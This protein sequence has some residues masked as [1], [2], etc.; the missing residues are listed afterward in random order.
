[1]RDMPK[2]AGRGLAIGVVP[3]AGL[4]CLAWLGS[5]AGSPR[6]IGDS[7]AM[8]WQSAL[9][10][11]GAA[12]AGVGGLAWLA[13]TAWLLRAGRAL[14]DARRDSA[15]PLALRRAAARTGVEHVICLAVEHPLAFCVGI[16]RPRIVVSKG[17]VAVLRQRELEAVLIHE[18]HHRR[19]RDPLRRVAQQAAADVV[20]AL[21]LLEWA[22]HRFRERS[23]LAADRAAIAV[24]GPEPVAGALW[25]LGSPAAP[26]AAAGFG[27]AATLR[28][29]QVLGDPLPARRPAVRLW[30]ASA[31]GLVLTALL[32]G[33]LGQGLMA[34]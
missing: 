9:L 7:G 24:L 1:M 19:R 4:A 17:L 2:W 3:G 20:F 31:L 10:A 34:L 27:G 18:E 14:A 21:P 32:A 33:C 6:C 25:A 12:L 15:W 22:M 26:Y 5:C 13:R 8:A 23:E 16:V 28:V 29:S 30:A 11:G